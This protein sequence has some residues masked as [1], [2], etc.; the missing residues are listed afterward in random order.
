M[1]VFL[2]ILGVIVPTIGIAIANVKIR[3]LS[4]V[5]DELASHTAGALTAIKQELIAMRA[6]V[7]QNHLALDI[8]LAKEGGVCQVLF[9]SVVF[10]CLIILK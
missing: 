10:L 6:M 9:G 1:T 4:T 2:D 8:I 3:K 5:V 7:M